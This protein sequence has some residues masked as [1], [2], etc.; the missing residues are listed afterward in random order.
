MSQWP[1][2]SLVSALYEGMIWSRMW[3]IRS[4][5][6]SQTKWTHKK[7]PAGETIRCVTNQRFDSL[8]DTSTEM[9]YLNELIRYKKTNIRTVI[10]VILW[11]GLEIKQSKDVIMPWKDVYIVALFSL[12]RK[13]AAQLFLQH[14]QRFPCIK[15]SLQLI[16]QIRSDRTMYCIV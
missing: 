5:S 8:K 16:W 2:A 14:I 12:I 3:E 4:C 1:K 13:S 11:Y 10:I 7:T 9:I 15:I 6:L